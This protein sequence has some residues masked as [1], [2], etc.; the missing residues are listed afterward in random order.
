MQEER[1]NIIFTLVRITNTPYFE[2]FES[3]I[4]W[5]L[6]VLFWKLAKK[7]LGIMVE[8][9]TWDIV[10][11]LIILSFNYLRLKWRLQA[12]W[13]KVIWVSL[14]IRLLCSNSK[15]NSCLT[16]CVL[17][18]SENI[19]ATPDPLKRKGMFLCQTLVQEQCICVWCVC[20]LDF[21]SM[22]NLS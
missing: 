20:D 17:L 12:P 22:T 18:R 15:E 8:Q 10:L 7:T 6:W 4:Q 16:A 11:D 9:R 3:V 1:H 5:K 14:K 13:L 2:R 19:V 21:K